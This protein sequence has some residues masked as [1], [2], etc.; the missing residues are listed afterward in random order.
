MRKEKEREKE[1]EDYK[2][3]NGL[4]FLFAR[5]VTNSA[6]VLCCLP[7]CTVPECHRPSPSVT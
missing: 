7:C 2:K 4:F 6:I 1:I 3:R 5:Q